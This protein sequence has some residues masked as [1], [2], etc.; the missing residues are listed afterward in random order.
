MATNP[1]SFLRRF[2]L[3][4]LIIA[5][6]IIALGIYLLIHAL[7]TAGGPG[8]V[9]PIVESSQGGE[10]TTLIGEGAGDGTTRV[11]LSEGSEQLQ[12]PVPPP[13]ATGEPLS[14]TGT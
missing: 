14:E 13:R 3:P 9:I 6:A 7:S 5:A 11:R 10:V 12:T 8:S 1:K 2:W 4:I